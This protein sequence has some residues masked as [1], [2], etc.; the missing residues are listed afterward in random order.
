MSSAWFPWEVEKWEWEAAL[1]SVHT[2]LVHVWTS[3]HPL[4]ACHPI[5]PLNK[6]GLCVGSLLYWRFEEDGGDDFITSMHMISGCLWGNFICPRK[7]F[8]TAALFQW[9]SQLQV[10]LSLPCSKTCDWCC[11]VFCVAICTTSRSHLVS[12]EAHLVFFPN[13]QHFP[14]EVFWCQLKQLLPSSY[15]AVYEDMLPF[16]RHSCLAYANT[17]AVW[18]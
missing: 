4:L 13:N 2:D 7:K 17:D 14:R 11:N 3:R 8:F 15:V 9:E 6:W 12:Q 1:P 10:F 18:G 16:M 5:S